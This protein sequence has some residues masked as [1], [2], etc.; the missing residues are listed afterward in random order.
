MTG[1]YV[2]EDTFAALV[3]RVTQLEEKLN[4][5]EAKLA[6]ANTTIAAQAAE[7]TSLRATIASQAAEITSLR[8]TIATQA[9]DI[10]S[11]RA[12]LAVKQ[13]TVD[14]LMQAAL[15]LRSNRKPHRVH[16]R[17]QYRLTSPSFAF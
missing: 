10:S 15:Q 11:L 2:Q 5:T 17:D 14:H 7:N 3:Q 13:S 8:A 16:C 4:E 9:T 1:I 12:N 6:Q